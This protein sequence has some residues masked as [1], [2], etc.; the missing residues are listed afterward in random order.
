[1]SCKFNRKQGALIHF[2][3]HPDCRMVHPE[4][5]P[6]KNMEYMKGIIT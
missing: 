4:G 3:V 1:M 5:L 6:G 2:G